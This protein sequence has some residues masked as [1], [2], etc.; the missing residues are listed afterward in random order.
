M[1][2]SVLNK[3]LAIASSRTALVGKA[4]AR[5]PIRPG[6]AAGRSAQTGG[7]HSAAK[8]RRVRLPRVHPADPLFTDRETEADRL[9]VVS[10]VQPFPS[11]GFFRR[12][13]F[14]TAATSTLIFDRDG[15]A[16]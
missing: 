7:R 2:A 3:G 14:F 12:G 10:I 8:Q 16:G 5:C 4:A 6:Q 11:R 13:F 9:A 15:V 1:L